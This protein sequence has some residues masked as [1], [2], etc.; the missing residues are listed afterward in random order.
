M[1]HIVKNI[2]EYLKSP[3]SE[4][5]FHVKGEWGSGK[6]YFFKEILPGEIRDDVDRIQVMIS[7]FGLGSVKEIPFRLLN[8][9]INKKSELTGSVS[10]EMNRGLDYLDMKYGVDRKLFGIDLHDEDELIYNIIPR[11]EV[12][13]CFDDV[14]RFVTA[15]NVEEIM[16][17]INNLVEN[18]GY[19]VIVISNDHY[20]SKDNEAAVVQSQFKEKVIGRA[21]S[22]RPAI[23]DIYNSIVVE[24]GDEA[25]TAF[26]MREDVSSLF[27][28]ENRNKN[29]RKDFENIRNIK[30]AISNFYGVF[31]H[32]RDTVGDG[33]TVKSL[34]YYLAFII[35]VSIEYKK[36]RLTDDDCHGID[37]DT[38]VFSLYL[39][40]DDNLSE[41][42]LQGLFGEIEDTPDEK[43][44]KEKKS[45]FDA[46]YRRRFYSVYAKGV[47]QKN[48]FHEEIYKSITNGSPI[49]YRKLEKNLQKKVFDN[50]R[51]DHPGNVVVAQSLDGTIFND[52]DEEIKSK[53]Q[54]LL[55][56]VSD[57]SLRMCAAYVNAFSFLDVYRSV[58][59][60]SHEEL[61]DIFKSGFSKYASNHEIDR[62]EGTGLEMVA[63]S[64]PEGTKD[65]YEY[66][67]ETLHN[68]W[69]EKQNQ[70][71]EEMVNLFKTDISGF[72]SLFADN[73]HGVT[74]H[75]VSDAVLHHIPGELVEERML[76][77][78]PK[79]VRSLAILVNQRFTPQD[80]F[81]FHLRKEKPFLE[82]MKKGIDAINGDD[83][84]SKVE[85]KLVLKPQVEK[86][87]RNFEIAQ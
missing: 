68:K 63:Q 71:I 28:P 13:L 61:L 15:N 77:L 27:M 51:E 39:D 70:G 45:N 5:A 58:V 14:E 7:L 78:T 74:F 32:F 47:N 49:D 4:G 69:L 57:G 46:I 1:E 59:G 62:M 16:G 2:V 3:K 33:K 37:V 50:E 41:S 84:V 75:Y 12:Y 65:F 6:T 87:L 72:C 55:S 8:A 67:R 23:R 26:M 80:I 42:E 83:T 56:S 30:F 10:E 43:E 34:K 35:G 38:D 11:E 29:Y 85:A 22:F 48:V 31:K 81:S 44:R 60:K 73:N 54:T 79:D 24:Y 66:L 9:Y 25:F 21:V 82:A 40:E 20:P 53:L 76:K 64:I 17:T 36:D 19:K 18:M 86:A 52:T